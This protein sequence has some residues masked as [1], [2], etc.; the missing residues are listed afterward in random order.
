VA[1]LRHLDDYMTL[2]HRAKTSL[3]LLQLTGANR[4][5]E[6]DARY[7]PYT[8]NS[9][10]ATNCQT[11]QR[12]S[13]LTR[14]ALN[15]LYGDVVTPDRFREWKRSEVSSVALLDNYAVGEIHR[16]K[17]LGRPDTTTLSEGFAFEASQEQWVQTQT[18]PGTIKFERFPIPRRVSW[19]DGKSDDERWRVAFLLG[20]LVAGQTVDPEYNLYTH[21]LPSLQR[22]VQWSN[23]GGEFGVATTGYRTIDPPAAHF[24]K[25]PGIVHVSFEVVLRPFWS[26]DRDGVG[27]P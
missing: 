22:S 25:N 16:V 23:P 13:D 21:I 8:I 18:V 24:V 11:L 10:R 1:A 26:F 2:D 4:T 20:G 14:D 12:S 3:S 19:W 7:D 27:Q 5:L 17:S 15:V 9:R 6:A